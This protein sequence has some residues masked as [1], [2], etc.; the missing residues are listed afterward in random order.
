MSGSRA[1]CLVSPFKT[2]SHCYC[3]CHFFVTV[4]DTYRHRPTPPLYSQD[5][6]RRFYDFVEVLLP[7][8]LAPPAPISLLIMTV[9]F[10]AVVDNASTHSL[11]FF[12]VSPLLSSVVRCGIVGLQ[13]HHREAQ[14][15]VLHCFEEIMGLAMPQFP[16]GEV[17]P[18]AQQCGP[19]V[20]QVRCACV[21]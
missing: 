16:G 19:A 20:E 4:V 2:F 18:R 13:L 8:F 3:M 6:C 17:N 1:F 7:P 5:F 10:T 12:S 11:C 9:G 21:S 15:G 14:K